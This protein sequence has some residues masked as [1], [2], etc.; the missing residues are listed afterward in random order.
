M[1]VPDV[2]RRPG[3]AYQHAFD[4]LAVRLHAAT[5][6]ACWVAAG[7][8]LLEMANRLPYIFAPAEVPAVREAA[9][10]ALG[11]PD[12]SGDTDGPLRAAALVEPAALPRNAV[13]RLA[14][15]GRLYIIAGGRA[16]R[17]LAERRM[18]D[19]P[20]LRETQIVALAQ[21]RG[22]RVIERLGIHPLAAVADHYAGEA[23]LALGRRDWRDRRHFA[24]RRDFVTDGTTASWSALVCLALERNE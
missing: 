5:P 18:N 19:A 1:I 12:I 22:F 15:E 17:F 3:L 23:A 21:A 8:Q 11:L 14:P 10:A 7:W 16:A 2:I 13:Q 4:W 6:M 24:M 9:A 20:A